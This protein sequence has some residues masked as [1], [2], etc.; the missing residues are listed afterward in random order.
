VDPI[1]A[2]V[3][4]TVLAPTRRRMAAVR[5]TGTGPARRVWRR[6]Y[7]AA[8]TSRTK[9]AVCAPSPT[10]PIIRGYSHHAP[11]TCHA[12]AATPVASD[13]TA[14]TRGPVYGTRTQNAAAIMVGR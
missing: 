10:G 11:A 14:S 8:P 4:T 3:S 2:N 1:D 12:S 7:D 9:L 5:A 6:S 13:S